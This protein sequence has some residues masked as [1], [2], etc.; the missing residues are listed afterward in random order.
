[1]ANPISLVERHPSRKA[2]ETALLAGETLKS[3]SSRYEVSPMVLSRYKRNVIAPALRNAKP[4]M[5]LQD[6]ETVVSE[7]RGVQADC[8]TL[9]RQG[10]AASIIERRLDDINRVLGKAEDTGD[11]SAWA[12]IQKGETASLRLMA[13]L[14][15]ELQPQSTQTTAIVLLMPQQPT[16]VQPM[17]ADAIDAEWTPG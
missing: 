7:I 12:S 4:K 1:M 8:K 3:I 17:Q 14:S 5:A 15:G 2:I 10:S 16:Q 6:S 9:I 11:L 13:E